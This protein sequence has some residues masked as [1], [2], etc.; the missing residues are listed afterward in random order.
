M[1]LQD[2]DRETRQALAT[3]RRQRDIQLKRER[4]A[5]N[6]ACGLDGLSKLLC[7]AAFAFGEHAGLWMEPGEYEDGSVAPPDVSEVEI[8]Y[9]YAD[10][11]LAKACE[12][13]A[14]IVYQPRDGKFVEV[15]FETIEGYCKPGCECSWC[16][17]LRQQQRGRIE[18]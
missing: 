2:I 11:W 12:W 17:T 5:Q 6:I 1:S 10:L 3:D 13:V 4:C 8:E 9:A 16:Q 18:A 14:W 7:T 15:T